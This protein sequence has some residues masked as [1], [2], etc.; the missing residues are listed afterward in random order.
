[1]KR[2][3]YPLVVI[4]IVMTSCAKVYYSPDAKSLAMSHKTIAIMPPTVSIAARK[5]VDAESIKEQQKTESANFQKEMYA[6]L[7]KRKM[8]GQF[9]VE[10][11]EIDYTNAMLRKEGYPDEPMTT[12]EI[13]SL[14]N[15]DGLIRSNYALSKPM[16]NGGAIALAVLGGGA[17][18]TNEA[19]ISLS[20]TD[21]S[22]GK[23]IF[24]YDHKLSGGM[25]SSSSSV[26]DG[27]LRR[28]SKKFPHSQY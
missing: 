6:W 10:F 13:C 2:I 23:L 17:A 24:N 5:K 16:S 26:V 4:V 14:L 15:V 22:S 11:Q 28:V 8:Q 25:G 20:I 7:L 19:R 21:C 1:M 27:L 9:I 12:S 18:A 3:I